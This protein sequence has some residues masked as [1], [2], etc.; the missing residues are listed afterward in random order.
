MTD[1]TDIFWHACDTGAGVTRGLLRP[2]ML[3]FGAVILTALRL[4][5]RHEEAM[6][7][8]RL[9]AEQ[10]RESRDRVIPGG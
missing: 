5:Q 7:E 2:L 10:V 4:G 3:G 1:C 9:R 8:A 6:H